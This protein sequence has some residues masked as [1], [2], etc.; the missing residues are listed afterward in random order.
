MHP[1]SYYS[2]ESSATGQLVLVE[3]P[4]TVGERLSRND[5]AEMSVGKAIRQL[6]VC[7]AANCIT[8]QYWDTASEFILNN[9]L[10]NPLDLHF[11]LPHLQSSSAQRL[12]G[13]SDEQ[14]EEVLTCTIAAEVK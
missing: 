11:V 3:I 14:P 6:K 8:R 13:E 7:K 4:K 10:L 2:V 9:A 5:E 12:G 1:N